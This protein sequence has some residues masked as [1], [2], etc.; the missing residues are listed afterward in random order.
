MDI[1]SIEANIKRCDNEIAELIKSIDSMIASVKGGSS[2]TNASVASVS[3]AVYN[4]KQFVK[5]NYSGS[6]YNVVD[7]PNMSVVDFVKY[8]KQYGLYQTAHIG[9]N[10]FENRCLGVAKAYAR[11]LMTI[12]KKI[13][14]N[15]DDF[16]GGAYTYFDKG[17][18]ASPNKEY[19]LRVVYQELIKGR[20]CVIQVSTKKGNRHFATVVGMKETV[21][22]ASELKEEDLLIIDAWDGNLE[23]MD[24]SETADRHMHA[25]NGKYRVDVFLPSKL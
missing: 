7:S 8:I 14:K 11:S 10:D 3:G 16:Y 12:G 13:P 1:A 6:T 19:V 5:L 24:D 4:G 2:A 21:T 17:D 15:I 9:Y 20:P 25:E 22:N 18:N 23:A